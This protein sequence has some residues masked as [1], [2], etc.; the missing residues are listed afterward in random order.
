MPVDTSV[1]NNTRSLN[2][3]RRAEEEFQMR[4]AAALQE[5]ALN[6][7]R[8]EQLNQ[9]GGGQGLPAA[10]VIANQ[11]QEARKAGDTQRI[12]DLLM[13]AKMLDRGVVMDAQ[14]APIEMGGYGQAIGGI[15]A[16][17]K[18]MATQ[19]QKNVEAVMNP[20]IEGR[21]TL[22]GELAKTSSAAEL[23][24]QKKIGAGEITDVVKKA[25]GQKQLSTMLNSVRTEYGKLDEIGAIPS[26]RYDT[27]KNLQISAR[28]SGVGQALGSMAATKE[29]VI[30]GNIKNSIPRLM[31]AISSASGMSAKQMDSIPEMKLLKE[32]VSDPKQPIETVLK[33]LDDLEVLYGLGDAQMAPQEVIPTGQSLFEQGNANFKASKG[34][35][36]KSKYGL[37]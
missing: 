15:E 2:D 19:A 26:S 12:N 36:Y 22:A 35:N 30:R 1:F 9:P 23:E 24:R 11:L 31:S 33:T 10:V 3:Y 16:A 18:G 8:I 14:G 6:Q 20:I 17:K 34:N 29:Q 13:S 5:R 27:A 37:E 21:S 7:A 28:A 32:S 25:T 4:K